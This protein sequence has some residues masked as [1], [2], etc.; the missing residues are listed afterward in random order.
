LLGLLGRV[1]GTEAEIL[2]L[3]EVMRGDRR[4][5]ARHVQDEAM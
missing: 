1:I 5:G 2:K 3:V 4:G